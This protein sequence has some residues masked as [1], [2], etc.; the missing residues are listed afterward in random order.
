M[1]IKDLAAVE[2]YMHHF[3]CLSAESV[4]AAGVRTACVHSLHSCLR[5]STCG[6]VLVCETA[7][8]RQRERC[9]GSCQSLLAGVDVFVSACLSPS[10]KVHPH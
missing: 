3:N 4:I 9:T 5:V 10:L 2:S 7:R 6:L 1:K 8:E